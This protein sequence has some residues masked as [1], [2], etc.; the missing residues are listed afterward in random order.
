M[1]QLQG[2]HS[3][4]Y[5]ALKERLIKITAHVEAYIDFESDET[6]DVG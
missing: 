6:N 5:L 1:M 2:K 3:K 4:V